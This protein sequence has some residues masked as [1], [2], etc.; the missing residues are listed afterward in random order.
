[1]SKKKNSRFDL[2]KMKDTGQSAVWIT[3]YDFWTASFAEE[4]GMDLTFRT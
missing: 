2:Q 3:A 4:A 1:M